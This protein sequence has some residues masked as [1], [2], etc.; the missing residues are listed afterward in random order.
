MSDGIYFFFVEKKVDRS[1]L[2]GEIYRRLPK[3][4]NYSIIISESQTKVEKTEFSVVFS[5]FD[6]DPEIII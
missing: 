2:W 4:C 3:R 1:V 5:T 6:H